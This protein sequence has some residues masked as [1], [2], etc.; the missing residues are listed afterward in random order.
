[1][2]AFPLDEEA[3]LSASTTRSM[4]AANTIVAE[5]RIVHLESSYPIKEDTIASLMKS[6]V[7]DAN[8]ASRMASRKML[9]ACTRVRH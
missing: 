2:I 6:L 5:F 8:G 9:S 3:F 1:V 7:S 4:A